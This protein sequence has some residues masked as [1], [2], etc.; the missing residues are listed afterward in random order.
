[1]PRNFGEAVGIAAP[2]LAA[3]APYDAWRSDEYDWA[4]G[5]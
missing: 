2:S 3:L 5:R 1:M 4:G